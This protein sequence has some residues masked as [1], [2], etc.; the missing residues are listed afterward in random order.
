MLRPMHSSRQL[1]N[2]RQP[3]CFTS[4]GLTQSGDFRMGSARGPLAAYANMEFR[5]QIFA[6]NRLKLAGFAFSDVGIAGKDYEDAGRGVFQSA[7]VGFHVAI[8][9]VDRLVLRV[10]YGWG[11][12]EKIQTPGISLGLNQFFQPYKPL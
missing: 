1:E 2:P 12:S 8:P 10:D 5:S 4:A 6:S 9:K 7:G 3:A 11:W